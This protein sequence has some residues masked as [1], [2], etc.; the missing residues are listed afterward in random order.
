M[1]P[2]EAFLSSTPVKLFLRLPSVG[3]LPTDRFN[4]PAPSAWS[5]NANCGGGGEENRCRRSATLPVSD[6]FTISPALS[7][8]TVSETIS[9]GLETGGE[10]SRG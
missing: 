2:T 10:D 8:Q 7:L 6:V 9:G 4:R 5:E 3:T 1:S